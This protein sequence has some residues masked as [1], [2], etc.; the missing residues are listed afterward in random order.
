M[1]PAAPILL[2]GLVL[3]G[4]WPAFAETDWSKSFVATFEAA[5]VPERLSYEGTLSNAIAEGWS[6]F[7]PARHAEFLAMMSQVAASVEEDAEELDMTFVSETLSKEVAERPLHLVVS[8]VKSEYLDSVGCYLYDFDATEP[9]ASSAVSNLLG[10]KPAQI[11]R[12]ET[13]E[14]AVW[15]PP[16]SMPRT[17][18]TYLTYIPPGSPLVTMAGFDGVVLKVTTSAPER[19]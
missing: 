17:L 11:H 13:I 3:S 1:R 18:D 2:T 4:A 6:K 8:F 10:V 12:D 7:D 5:C 16:P 15:G 9:V 19:D 14:G